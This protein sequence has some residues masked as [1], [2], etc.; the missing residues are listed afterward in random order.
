MTISG[1][2]IARNATKYFFPIKESIMSIL[3]IVDEFIIAL[4]EGDDDDNTEDLIRSIKSDKIKIYNRIW[5]E[6]LFVNGKIFKNETDFA[7]SNC[8]GDWCFYLQADEVI[9]EKYLG[10]IVSSSKKYLSNKQIEGFL[11]NYRHF[12]GDFNHYVNTHGW[13]KNEIRIIRNGMGVS[14]YKD[15]QSFRISG[16]KLRVHSLSAF[17]YHYGWVRPPW[18]MQSKKKEQASMHWGIARSNEVYKRETP[19]FDYGPLGRLPV[20]KDSHPEVMQDWISKFDWADD[21]NY[22]KK[23]DVDRNLIKHEKLKYRI[24]SWLEKNILKGNQIGA[25]KN[26]IIVSKDK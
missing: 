26:W 6:K 9:H 13:Y 7:L 15:A 10:Y 3:P 2:T 21:L 20:F 25:W 1:F 16:R 12:W 4:G 24:L 8:K 22:G 14:S 18:V 23:L 5:D 17:V 19:V 11:F